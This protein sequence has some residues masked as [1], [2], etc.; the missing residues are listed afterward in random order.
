MNARKESL[1]FRLL[2]DLCFLQETLLSEEKSING[3]ISRWPG[4]IFLSPAI[5]KQGGVGILIHDNFDGKVLSW[6]KDSSGH[7]LSVLIETSQ[8]CI[9]LVNI[10]VP[11]NLT[12]RKAFFGMRED[13]NLNKL[14]LPTASRPGT[15]ESV[16]VLLRLW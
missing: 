10:Y 11:T 8:L 7:V 9:N 15:L 13:F 4:Q 5:G 2:F 14:P 12:E 1:I 6:L 3:V 16:S